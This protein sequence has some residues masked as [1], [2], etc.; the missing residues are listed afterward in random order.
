MESKTYLKNL[1]ISPKKLR[2][3]LPAVKKMKPAK[4]L[5]YLFYTNNKPAKV[6]YQVIKSAISNA[7]TLLKV[8]DDMLNFK[9]LTVEEGQKLKRSRPGGRGTAKP[10]IKRMSHIKIVLEASEIPNSKHQITNKSQIQNS[11]SKTKKI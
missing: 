8:S 7:K 2:F 10:I 3:L 4:S 11:K 5:D 6:L 9:L 1:K